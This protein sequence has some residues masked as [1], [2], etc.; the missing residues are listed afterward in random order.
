MNV[1]MRGLL[2][3]V[4]LIRCHMDLSSNIVVLTGAGISAD[5]GVATFR[6][7]GGIWA[8]YDYREVATPEGYA[9]NPTLVH[10]FYNLRRSGL[11]EV[12][13]NAAHQA[14]AKLEIAMADAGGSLTLVTQN[15]DDLHERGGSKS[16]WHMHG[17]LRKVRCTACGQIRHWQQDLSLKTECPACHALGT[18]RPHIVWFGEM[19]MLMDEI[20]EAIA[21]ADQFV[22]IGTSGSVYPAA[23]FVGEARSLGIPCME[24]N[25]EP[26]ENAYLFDAAFYGPAAEQV[27]LW[28]E[29]LLSSVSR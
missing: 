8:K 3:P 21:N 6:D 16:V 14:L 4:I 9:A 18:L 29:R 24:I 13:P 7:S 23:G 22:S 5:S 27:P 17:E 11:N 28:V 12:E 20:A 26:S 1:T 19:P 15:V 2:R 10:E 25:L